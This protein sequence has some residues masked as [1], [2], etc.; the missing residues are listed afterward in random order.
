M[1][2]STPPLTPPP[3][4]TPVRRR[5]LLPALAAAL[6]AGAAGAWGWFRPVPVEP[7]MPPEV[8]DPEVR[9]AIETA[10]QKVRAAP[11]SAAAWGDLGIVLLAH[12][13]YPEADACFA[14][15]ARLEPGN[16]RWPYYR[17]LIALTR[18]TDNALPLLRQA[19]ALGHPDPAYQSALRLR[20]AETLLERDA[21]D[22]AEALFREELKREPGNPRAALGLGLIAQLHG[23]QRAA[24]D[25]LS[26][27][28]FSP[29][30]QKR[31]TAQLAVLARAH[32][33]DA[34]ADDLEQKAAAMPDDPGGTVPLEMPDP[35]VAAV[36]RA[37][38]GRHARL[39][40]IDELEKTHQYAR[41]A[42]IFLEQLQK[43]RTATACSGA[44]LNLGRIGD[45]DR[46]L[47]LLREAIELEPGRAEHHYVLAV[48]LFRQAEEQARRS[49]DAPQVRQGFREAAE[50]ARRATER[51]ADYA[52]AYLLWGRA[53]LALKEPAAAVAPLRRG[54]VCRPE[55]FDLQLLLGEALLD[56]G[57]EHEA[58][59][60]L[61]NARKLR[62]KDERALQALERLHKK[63]G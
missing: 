9:H 24:A 62:P 58:A 53:L 46:A 10:R 40:E 45:Y 32:G 22:E 7:P 31:A 54:I 13:C 60:H 19:A 25:L 8:S 5:W 3:A 34:A 36:G 49:P 50:S 2:L 21:V 16:A 63:G 4:A 15:A 20:L 37:E 42:E 39:R 56:A 30:T 48:T 27:A 44:G 29:L 47:P 11:R 38:V 43:E 26:V 51:K 1:T 33:D 12:I 61:E 41:A 14:E 55:N 59:V 23:D 52:L 17:G 18:D 57:Q 6:L 35:F 28:R